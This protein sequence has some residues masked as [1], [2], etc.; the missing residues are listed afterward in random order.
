MPLT[1]KQETYLGI[2]GR[3]KQNIRTPFLDLFAGEIAPLPTTKIS[4]DHVVDDTGMADLVMRGTTGKVLT[5]SNFGRYELIPGVIDEEVP[6]TP[7]ELTM[8]DAGDTVYYGGKAVKTGTIVAERK[9]QVLKNR[10]ARRKDFMCAQV[11]KNGQYETT[12]G[13]TCSFTLRDAETESYSSTVN[14]V[15]MLYQHFANFAALNGKAP[16]TTLLNTT[17]IKKL[18]ADT[19]FQDTVQKLG[20]AGLTATQDM[21]KMVIGRV[22]N[23]LLEPLGVALDPDKVDIFEADETTGLITMINKDVL[24]KA[25]AG[26]EYVD[27]KTGNT[28]MVATDLFMDTVT[29]K[30]P[31][32]TNLFVQSAFSPIVANK[33]GI[34][35]IDV[36]IA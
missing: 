34:Y 14:F 21:N 11:L 9:A 8:M 25:H 3:V 20:I 35:R 23:Q 18:M 28:D 27:E 33:N 30:R 7:E 13:N 31:A 19:K 6:V 36:T 2:I 17:L 26:I 24:Y 32:G 12:D 16:D 1:E 4:Y 10:V 15:S 22:L 29:K 5:G